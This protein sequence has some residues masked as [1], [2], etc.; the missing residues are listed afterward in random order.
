MSLL[1]AG[2]LSN[3]SDDISQWQAIQI[4]AS[5]QQAIAWP[6]VHVTFVAHSTL[7]FV[8]DSKLAVLRIVHNCFMQTQ[9]AN[10]NLGQEKFDGNSTVLGG[11]AILELALNALQNS[12][13]CP[14]LQ[15]LQTMKLI[16]YNRP[17]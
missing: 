7:S 2:G 4:N 13:S 12:S 8:N 14:V 6:S 16:A 15:A 11:I 3:A 5:D 1:Y 9:G 17:W 10:W